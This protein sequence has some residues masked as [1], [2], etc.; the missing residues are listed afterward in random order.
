MANN[1]TIIDISEDMNRV[2]QAITKLLHNRSLWNDFF[3]QPETVLTKLGLP[4]RFGSKKDEWKLNRIFYA[5]L[6][7]KKLVRLVLQK[8]QVFSSTRS[9]S[10]GNKA[11][12]DGL[13]QGR[14]VSPPNA[15][16]E[17][18]AFFTKNQED[19]R[20]FLTLALTDLNQKGLLFE[21]LTSEEVEK[22]INL[23]MESAAETMKNGGKSSQDIDSGVMGCVVGPVCIAV[24]LV[25]VVAQAAVGVTPL[26]L[27]TYIPNGQA[28][29][30]LIEQS[31]EGDDG[32]AQALWTM[33]RL[34]ELTGEL[35][36]FINRMER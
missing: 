34:L 35:M 12:L 27:G 1:K 10:E 32:S 5:L 8:Y 14:L 24:C 13:K 2:D 33:G 31:I 25:G 20:Q 21:Q 9:N 3:L 18:F 36:L 30:E 15:D 17:A 26:G 4:P 6:T 11:V 23:M 19:F 16:M 28:L 22:R 7:N 29:E